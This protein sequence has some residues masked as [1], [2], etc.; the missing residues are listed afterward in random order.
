MDLETYKQQFTEDDAVGWDCIDQQLANIYGEQEPRH[1]APELPYE[2][3]G[4]DPLNGVSFYTSTEQEP[5]FHFVTYGFSE[6][7]Y[8]EDAVGEEFSKFGFEL[9]FR[10]KMESEEDDEIGWVFN[11]LQNIARYVFDSGKW[12]EPYHFLPAGA[13]IKMDSDSEITALAFVPDPELGKIDTPHG[14]VM[15]LQAVGLT[16]AEFQEL[17]KNPVTTETEKLINKL[18]QDNRLLVTDLDRK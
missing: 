5:H 4:E 6:L 10:L 17:K 18:R 15:F 11:M 1:Y 16:T 2:L 13:P 8:D 12:F 7:F 9:T 3:G 14:E